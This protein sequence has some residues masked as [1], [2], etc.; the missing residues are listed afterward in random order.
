MAR[1]EE[2]F[3]YAFSD[4]QLKR[5]PQNKV[6]DYYYAPPSMRELP[7]EWEA[8]IIQCGFH[9]NII[10]MGTED[11]RIIVHCKDQQGHGMNG[12]GSLLF[13]F[14]TPGNY[15]DCQQF[16]DTVNAM[17]CYLVYGDGSLGVEHNDGPRFDEFVKV[18]YNPA[19][20]RITFTDSTSVD[21]ALKMNGSWTKDLVV[22]RSFGNK[23]G[24]QPLPTDADAIT[25]LRVLELGHIGQVTEL[26]LTYMS[27]PHFLVMFTCDLISLSTIGD[28]QVPLARIVPTGKAGAYVMDEPYTPRYTTVTK[29]NLNLIRMR[30]VD[31]DS[32]KIR[33]LE[34]SGQAFAVLHVRRIGIYDG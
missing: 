31:L 33:F 15:S 4:R 25:T 29:N 27:I 5:Y 23:L 2:H 3:V 9:N 16:V 12:N 22:K 1:A 7:G 14:P 20:Q 24:M 34:G 8:A 30:V 26:N 6:S 17:T 32:D 18:K 11:S 21:D 10:N 28:I 13:S 19:T